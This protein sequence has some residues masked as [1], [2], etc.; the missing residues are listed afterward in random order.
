MKANVCV[1]IK[2]HA[3]DPLRGVLRTPA[4]AQFKMTT[5]KMEMEVQKE[6]VLAKMKSAWKMGLAKVY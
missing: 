1:M 6:H 5:M 2:N 3:Q 4:S